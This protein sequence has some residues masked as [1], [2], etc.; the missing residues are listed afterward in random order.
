MSLD[1]RVALF[2]VIL[3][4]LA[5]LQALINRAMGVALT[6]PSAVRRITS[7]VLTLVRGAILL[8]LM[9]SMFF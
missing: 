4:G 7:E 9:Q 8:L 3:V 6:G 5:V 2:L 1:E